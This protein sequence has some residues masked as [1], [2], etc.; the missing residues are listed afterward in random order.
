MIDF[1]D[2]IIGV[3]MIVASVIWL[4]LLIKRN[5]KE[6][7]YDYWLLSYDINIVFGLIVFIVLGVLYVLRAFGL[8]IT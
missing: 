3:V 8:S 5:R 1:T 4:I 7:N 6:K 2:L